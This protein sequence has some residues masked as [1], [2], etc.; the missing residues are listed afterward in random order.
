MTQPIDPH[1]AELAELFDLDYGDFADDLPL[2]D[3]LARQSG[4]PILELGVGTG[5]VALRLARSGYEVSGIENNNAMLE[6]ARCK[7]GDATNPQFIAGDM[8][9]FNLGQE[10]ALIYAGYGAFHHLLT[11]ADQL[12]CLQA[13]ERHM[14]PDS[15]LVFDLRA[16]F[17]TD[18]EE[19]GSVPLLHDWTRVH[20]DGSMVT[21]LRSI[22][23]DR[24]QQMQHETYYYDRV[25][26]NG[27][28][29]RIS[30][31]V[32]LRFSTRYEIEA[33]LREAGLELDGLYGD[34]DLSAYDSDSDLMITVARKR[35]TG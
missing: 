19:G 2:Y 20:S 28:L 4:G 31:N 13:A 17:A 3:S 9:D 14:K 16:I 33:L 1:D 12:A 10:F 35:A 24:A 34:F 32:D 7:A 8:R 26:A 30:T 18:W 6:R 22:R 29:R 27:G 25:A 23:V 5:R 11:P 15:V 21:K